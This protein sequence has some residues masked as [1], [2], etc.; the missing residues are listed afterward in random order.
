[1][2]SVRAAVVLASVFAAAVAF[3]QVPASAKAK[4]L[5]PAEPAPVSIPVP[6]DPKGPTAGSCT[7]AADS[8]ADFEG[9]FTG[10]D[11][12]ASCEKGKG[13]WSSSPCPGEGTVGTCTQR[14]DGSED[15]IL[16]RSYPP[17][18]AEAARRA[19]VRMPRGIFLKAK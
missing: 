6:E 10:Q 2:T 11:L 8:C 7:Y 9:A 1:M 16:T 12:R 13:T 15:R 19:C 14:Q 4:R 18:T 3:A 17:T 5:A